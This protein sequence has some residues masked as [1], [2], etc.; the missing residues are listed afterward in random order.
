[1]LFSQSDFGILPKINL[2]Y[3][4]NKNIKAVASVESR[5]FF[6]ENEEFTYRYALTDYQFFLSYKLNPTRS[7][8]TGFT[9]R[10]QNGQNLI[11]LSQQ[12]SIVKNHET[13]RI[14]HRMGMDITRG[15]T[16][17]T[18]IRSRYRLTYEKPFSGMRVD[19]SEFYLKLGN[20]LIL[21]FSENPSV[22]LEYRILSFIGY[23]INYT[24]RIETGID[25]RIGKLLREGPA[26]RVLMGI[27]W[28]ANF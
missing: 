21:I 10:K 1:M 23:E 16:A 2:S 9:F 12:Y 4:L 20:E 5:Q 28:Y 14:G 25:L 7:I 26:L 11:R 24:N 6:Y 18:V 3:K 8:N 15:A 22:N 17:P 13:Y 27:T 19:P